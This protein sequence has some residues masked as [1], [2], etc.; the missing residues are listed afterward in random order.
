MISLLLYEQ[1]CC[2][3][4]LEILRGEGC[5][6][7]IMVNKLSNLGRLPCSAKTWE[8]ADRLLLVIHHSGMVLECL[9]GRARPVVQH[10]FGRLAPAGKGAIIYDSPI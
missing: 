8:L 10:I 1:S 4:I 5:T 7:H 6:A 2:I 9:Y 3:F